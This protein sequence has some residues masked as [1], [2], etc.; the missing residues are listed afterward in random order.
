MSMAAVSTDYAR[1]IW[2]SNGT[3]VILALLAKQTQNQRQSSGATNAVPQERCAAALE[4]LTGTLVD[5]IPQ[6]LDFAENEMMD[7]L[8]DVLASQL[9]VESDSSSSPCSGYAISA[10]Y[11]LL[12]CKWPSNLNICDK[13][14]QSLF[15][16]TELLW[17][18]L[19]SQDNSA[20]V[21]ESILG[22]IGHLHEACEHDRTFSSNRFRLLMTFLGKDRPLPLHMATLGLLMND[23]TIVARDGIAAVLIARVCKTLKKR[24]E[25][26]E[27]I[28]LAGLSVI[29]N[30]LQQTND[31][32]QPT[33]VKKLIGST[34]RIMTWFPND[35][36][37][38]QSACTLLASLAYDAKYSSLFDLSQTGVVATIH[39]FEGIFSR[40][41]SIEAKYAVTSILARLP[42]ASMSATEADSC[43]LLLVEKAMREEPEHAL[44]GQLLGII[45]TLLKNMFP[46][47]HDSVSIAAPTMQHDSV[48]ISAPTSHV[49]DS[50]LDMIDQQ[51]QHSPRDVLQC[52]V[53]L[54]TIYSTVHFTPG[55][56]D[57]SITLV[58]MGLGSCVRFKTHSTNE[59]VTLW[60]ALAMGTNMHEDPNILTA[61]C[62]A[63][64]NYLDPLCALLGTVTDDAALEQAL[65]KRELRISSEMLRILHGTMQ[66]HKTNVDVTV[67][68]ME[69]FRILV[70]LTKADVLN[71]WGVEIISLMVKSMEEWHS[72]DKIESTGLNIVAMLLQKTRDFALLSH[73]DFFFGV[74]VRGLESDSEVAVLQAAWLLAGL[75]SNEPSSAGNSFYATD[76]CSSIIRSMVRHASSAE[77]Q[78]QC[79]IILQ[80]GIGSQPHVHQIADAQGL[81]AIANALER[82]SGLAELVKPACWVLH[83]M[84]VDI[85]KNVLWDH[86]RLVGV[87]AASCMKNNVANHAAATKAIAN[88][89]LHLCS[90]KDY[91]KAVLVDSTP[92]LLQAMRANLDDESLQKSA[93]SVI[94]L[95]CSFGEGR[96]LAGPMGAVDSVLDALLA[97]RGSARL[98]QEGF[99]ALKMLIWEEVASILLEPLEIYETVVCIARIHLDDPIIQKEAMAM[100]T[101]D[102]TTVLKDVVLEWVIQVMQQHQTDE[103]VQQSACLCLKSHMFYP[104]SCWK[105][106]QQNNRLQEL[107]YNSVELFWPT[108]GTT[109]VEIAERIMR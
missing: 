13:T 34:T 23:T 35:L 81:Q 80:Q 102:N 4:V 28:H 57:G 69:L 2:T 25:T 93:C 36:L 33:I 82:H 108:C 48:S 39:A 53:L 6:D 76:T 88:V 78:R 11:H 62:C 30:L 55:D 14:R 59:F 85:D 21:Q 104:T 90:K 92:L 27:S 97:H 42:Q 64:S 40:N 46:I 71:E 44:K 50:I 16:N 94:K 47:Q 70:M 24:H 3:D 65:G 32:L 98:V 63:L 9:T 43:L 41:A 58:Q 20:V 18:M 12:C 87:A 75:L 5:V 95:L 38:Q 105:M 74:I 79:C 89:W 99:L 68:A 86:R 91:F 31:V 84:L 106:K 96:K 54:A 7:R 107:L 19:E 22:I 103:S 45:R 73:R 49:I 10:L 77:V 8:V 101:L 60:N 15:G 51:Q 26:N 61:C 83:K 66:R 100:A 72:N 56:H 1:D 37:I 29:Q 17:K 67:H 109:A 52:Y